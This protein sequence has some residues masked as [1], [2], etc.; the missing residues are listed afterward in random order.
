MSNLVKFR[1]NFNFEHSFT[2]GR[3][4]WTVLEYPTIMDRV[5]EKGRYSATVNIPYYVHPARGDNYKITFLTI[6]GKQAVHFGDIFLENPKQS[7]NYIQDVVSYFENIDFLLKED[8]SGSIPRDW[9]SSKHVVSRTKHNILLLEEEEGILNEIK[10]DIVR[11]YKKQPQA[12]LYYDANIKGIP[13]EIS[14][15]TSDNVK[16]K[17]SPFRFAG[18]CDNLRIPIVRFF[19]LLKRYD[20]LSNFEK[21]LD[22]FLTKIEG[23]V[24]KNM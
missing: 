12:I 4:N 16:F 5:Q 23:E 7:I 8:I 11:I 17:F 20:L 15:S 14:I 1:Y 2:E 18:Y 3:I 10:N 24:L 22:K 19:T 21:R 6:R 13:K 9:L